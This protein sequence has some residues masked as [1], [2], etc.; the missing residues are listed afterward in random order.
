MVL[1][2]TGIRLIE[3][4]TARD[5]NSDGL[6]SATHPSKW[7]LDLQMRKISWSWMEKGGPPMRRRESLSP[8]KCT[9]EKSSPS[10]PHIRLML[11]GAEYSLTLLHF[12]TSPTLLHHLFKPLSP[13]TC[14]LGLKAWLQSRISYLFLYI[15]LLWLTWDLISLFNMMLAD[16]LWSIK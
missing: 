11:K 5:H 13:Q 4:Y 10:S 7:C 15:E 1:Y 14:F 8:I 6:D 16:V 3:N 9:Q 12:L 2:N